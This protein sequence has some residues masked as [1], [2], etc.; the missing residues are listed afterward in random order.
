[1]KDIRS[2]GESIEIA[3]VNAERRSLLGATALGSAVAALSSAVPSAWAAQSSNMALDASYDQADA[4]TMA[5]WVRDRKVSP[6]ELLGEAIKRSDLVNS[7][8][9]FLAENHYQRAYDQ[10]GKSSAGGVFAG[11]PFLLK[12]LGVQLKGTRTSGGS[13]LLKDHVASAN[14]EIVNRFERAGLVIFGKT[15]TPEFGMAL[16]TEGAF[17]GDCKNPWN[18]AH[19]TGGSSG[20]SAAAVAAGVLPVAHATDGGGSI[21][22]P[23]NHC[24]VFGLKPTRGRTPGASGPAM[25]IGH[26]VSKSVRDS[27]VM[28][29]AIS[30]PEP[31]GPY[32][33]P[34]VAGEFFAA[35]SKKSK[36]LRV[37]L[38]LSNPDVRIH[39][40][41][42]AAVKDAAE[43][44]ESM[45]HVVE[46]KATPVDFD[47]V[48]RVQ[49]TLI[50]TDMAAY[51][52]FVEAARGSPI[53]DGELEPMSH[54]IWREGKRYSGTDFAGAMHQMH[55]MGRAMGRFHETYDIV[56]QPVTSQPAPELGTII[57]RE[58]DDLETYTG[59]FKQVA[60]FTHLF[61][62]TGQPS[63]SVP[64][65][66]SQSGLPIGVMFTAA[67]GEDA[68]LLTLA[69]ELER[70]AP[71]AERKPGIHA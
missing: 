8:I 65:G 58:G 23:A 19:I 17:L 32:F 71:W 68:L 35:L 18:P 7:E 67:L 13:A 47:Q 26:V 20:G 4:V 33:Q 24:G 70:A 21:R 60:A 69:A 56:L 27:A 11:V 42:I 57:Y 37:A 29:D 10:L 9:N 15:N 53:K 38:N 50:A 45:G 16:T 34:K 51:F 36:R 14:N 43:L 49:N 44:L 54:M 64:L 46:E 22:V 1:M 12:D 66:M 6:R 48:N 2:K 3:T 63:M 59:R 25:S 61:N 5:Q 52:D 40:N 55:E 39:P 62:M 31:G 28:L 30:G 41:V